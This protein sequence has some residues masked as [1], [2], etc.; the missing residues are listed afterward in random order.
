M[1]S[2][3]TILLIIFSSCKVFSQV[4]D[5]TSTI[6]RAKIKNKNANI[7]LTTI[8]CVPCVAKL[9]HADSLLER[10]EEGE[11]ILVFDRLD[12]NY[13]KFKLLS[14]KNFDST[15]TFIIPANYYN[16][17]GPILINPS[18]KGMSRF[19]KEIL[20]LFPLSKI[21]KKYHNYNFFTVTSAGDVSL[22][23]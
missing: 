18:K 13:R 14:L 8:W 11:N 22:I 21:E 17:K 6:L 16:L 10:K 2:F 15:N 7:I 19:Y 3:L 1:K 12:F 5:I 23:Q 9:K 4:K 20:M